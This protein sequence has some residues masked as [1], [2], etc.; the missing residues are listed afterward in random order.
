MNYYKARHSMLDQTS[1]SVFTALGRGEVA[2]TKGLAAVF[3]ESPKA[4]LDLVAQT[5]LIN[6]ASAQGVSEADLRVCTDL[7][8]DSEERQSP[9]VGCRRDVV[10]RF[11][12]NS[13]RVLTVII[14]AKHTDV[15]A[16]TGVLDQVGKY[17][18][19]RGALDRAGDKKI[20]L[21]LTKADVIPLRADTA[22]ITWTRLTEIL[23]DSGSKM[24]E[25]FANHVRESMGLQHFEVEVYSVPVGRTSDAVEK[26]YIHA[27]PQSYSAPVCLYLAPRLAGGGEI[28]R[29]YRVERV[30]DLSTRLLTEQ[31]S[32]IEEIEADVDGDVGTRLRNYFADRVKITGEI[33]EELRVFVL[34]TK[35]IQL[36]HRPRPKRNNSFKTG[37]WSLADLLDPSVE[38]LP[39]I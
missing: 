13:S 15:Q 6:S 25:R 30:F 33:E 5:E 17:L 35:P 31:I 7:T 28:P 27:F 37:R 19:A 14:E 22:S 36:K 16:G 29:L 20:G 8:V 1:Q 2:L 23:A 39:S 26:T 18:D 4:A 32:R 34:G 24:A 9:G 38:V 10:L 21:T 11:L 12:H 3:A